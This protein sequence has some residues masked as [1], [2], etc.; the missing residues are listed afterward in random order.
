MAVD[1]IDPDDL[2]RLIGQIYDTVA[3]PET[4]P[5]VLERCA[6]FVGGVMPSI[7]WQD[8]IV[9]WA[10]VFYFHGEDP[11]CR[12][13][14]FQTY[15]GTNPLFPARSFVE[16]GIV[17]GGGDVVPHAEFRE[18]RF[19][20]E[21]VQSE[22]IFDAVGANL[23]CHP[24]SSACLAVQRSVEQR[25]VDQS[26]RAR[27]DMI[28]PHL[29]RAVLTGRE[30][31]HQKARSDGLEKA[32]GSLSTGIFLVDK[33]GRLS[34]ANEKGRQLLEE[35]SFLRLRGETL[36]VAHPKIDHALRCAL[37]SA[38]TG[39][40]AI[41]GEAALALTP[42]TVKPRWLATFLPLSTGARLKARLGFNA[43][44][45]II[46]R[47]A[48]IHV[49]SGIETIARIYGLTAAEM[50]VL[51]SVAVYASVEDIA[52]ALG[53]SAGTVKTHLTALFGKTGTH[54]RADLVREIA[55][56]GNPLT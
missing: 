53:I 38:A 48:E 18:T 22:G 32:L 36:S 43:D 20:K 35:G 50:R 30:L 40:P 49:A 3:N 8:A 41:D 27:M 34:L 45:A 14:Y 15:A 39:K 5:V 51:R 12:D 26:S 44:V 54:R 37:R 25:V 2:S 56:H 29:R 6:E 16:S 11:H 19:F 33:E 9:R 7:F 1:D 10:S 17:M 52:R 4:W 47:R 31:D 28:V 55:A 21:W 46:V 42:V 13:R 23:Q 24:T